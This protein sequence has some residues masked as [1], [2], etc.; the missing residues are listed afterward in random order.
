MISQTYY[1]AD[2]LKACIIVMVKRFLLEGGSSF[3]TFLRISSK[4]GILNF[5]KWESIQDGGG[6][7]VEWNARFNN[8]EAM[9]PSD[10]YG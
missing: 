7:F 4:A 6:M 5:L 2:V 1:M 3:S 10:V 9:L 8:N